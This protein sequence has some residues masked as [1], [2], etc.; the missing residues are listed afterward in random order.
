M[1]ELQHFVEVDFHRFKSFLRFTIRLNRFNILVGPN[2]AGK[3]TVLAAFRILAAAMRR[4]NTRKPHLV[5]GPNGPTYGYSI[6]LRSASV[7]EENLFYN[8]NDSEPAMVVFKLSNQNRLV[9]FFPEHGACNLFAESSRWAVMSPADFRRHFNCPIGFVPILGPVDHVEYFHEKEA[10]RLALFSYGAA[11]N[12]RNIWYHYPEKFD[13]FRTSLSQ[14]WPGMDIQLPEIVPPAYQRKPTLTMFCPE[15]RIPRE[16]SWS[17]F[18]FQVWCQMLTHMIQSNN[19]AL[20]MIDEPDIYLHSDLQRQL[21]GLLRDLGPD[22]LIATH[23]TEIITEAEADDIILVDKKQKLARRIKSSSQLGEVF[24]ILGSTLN[25]VLTQLAK[26]RRALFVEGGDFHLVGLFARKLKTQIVANRSE[27]AVVPVG[28]FNPERIRSLKEGMEAMLGGKILAAAILDG[29]FRGEEEK[30]RIITSLQKFCDYVTVHRRKEIENF[31]LVP[32]ALDRAAER[33]LKDRNRRTGEKRQYSYI[34][35]SVLEEFCADA[36]SGVLAQHIAFRKRH[37]RALSSG[38]DEATVNQRVLEEFDA[39]WGEMSSRLEVVPGKEALAQFN[40]QLQERYGVSI[41]P[42]AIVE[43]VLT[44]EVPREMREL[45]SG[46]AI[47]AQ[48]SV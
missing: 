9:L 47:F 27:F 18:G 36:R 4:A 1:N 12:F 17:G 33:R 28:G 8:Y 26:T 22:I 25:P 46:L 21:L 6:D 44:E 24:T 32:S 30:H 48:R 23:S 31:L 2:N 38:L 34:A 3:S 37:E 13:L 42:T 40:Q 15:E 20:F 11:R 16:I 19:M 7:S 41:T 10:A 39:S 29:D 43:A 35:E 45:V 5:A 14:T